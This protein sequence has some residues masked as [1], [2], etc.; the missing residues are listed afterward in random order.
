MTT[1]AMEAEYDASFESDKKAFERL[2][3]RDR[4]MAEMLA[5][6]GFGLRQGVVVAGGL[7][8]D[9]T[10]AVFNILVRAP[11][12]FLW[13][14]GVKA[15]EAAA[16][17]PSHI[18]TAARRG[19]LSLQG[20]AL[21]L[22]GKGV[23]LLNRMGLVS[24]KARDNRLA[25]IAERQ[26]EIA[27]RRAEIETAGKAEREKAQ[28]D[29]SGR[30]RRLL[31]ALGKAGGF[32]EY[33]GA[34]GLY[35]G[36]KWLLDPRRPG[37]KPLLGNEKLN[38][39]MGIVAATAVFGVLAYQLSKIVVLGKILHIKLAHSAVTAAAPLWFKL[40]QQTVLHPAITVGLTAV[41][42]VTLP[43][44]AAARGRMKAADFTQ[45]IAHAYNQRLR[46]HREQKLKRDFNRM[47]KYAPQA[48][49]PKWTEF[50]KK[51]AVA[52]RKQSFGFIRAF[53]HHI[54]EK[55][56]PEFYEVRHRHYA[57]IHAENK[58][59][60]AARRL[61]KQAQK[62]AP[63]PSAQNGVFAQN[64]PG[65]STRFGQAPKPPATRPPQPPAPA[66]P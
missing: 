45:G 36:F 38:R 3:P 51:A 4:R 25:R 44:I 21:G 14:Q 57:A 12:V 59:R 47:A 16:D 56:S 58:K 54:V 63:A 2:S 29:R 6:A 13:K 24:D 7:V 33:H 18:A 19:V 26:K 34:I 11:V 31:A 5:G 30:K 61:A 28:K 32:L 48:D 10:E 52:A 20:K 15:A 49:D 65:L 62:S 1:A 39:A 66:M 8:V 41:K 37:G 22:S 50:R 46:A 23:S 9:A 27:R 35:R 60:R 43:V 55:S 64:A 53:F 42:F 40:V 17:A